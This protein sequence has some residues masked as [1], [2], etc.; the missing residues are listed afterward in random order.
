MKIFRVIIE[1]I[2][3]IKHLKKLRFFI[4]SVNSDKLAEYQNSL[5]WYLD[6]LG[7]E[8]KLPCGVIHLNAIGKIEQKIL[9]YYDDREVSKI[10]IQNFLKD[11]GIVVKD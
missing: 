2:Q 9:V 6:Q 7:T 8:G 10:E 1:W 3:N 11:V 5:G 4:V